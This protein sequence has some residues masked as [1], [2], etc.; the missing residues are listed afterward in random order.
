M[1]DG[2]LLRMRQLA[3]RH[4][5]GANVPSHYLVSKNDYGY[6]KDRTAEDRE[7]WAV[8]ATAPITLFGIECVVSPLA[9]DGAPLVVCSV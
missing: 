9:K 3:G 6:I 8:A 7:R 4:T 5:Y 2:L 1:S